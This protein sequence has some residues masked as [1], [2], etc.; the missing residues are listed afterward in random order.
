MLKC[1]SFQPDHVNS[2]QVDAYLQDGGH[3]DNITKRPL[4]AVV[5]CPGGGYSYVSNRENFPVGREFLGAGYH[6]FILTYSTGKQAKDFEPLCQLAAT[7]S[8]IRNHAEEW[9]VDPSK[10]AVCGFSAGGHLAAS[11]GTLALTEEF[12][13]VWKGGDNIIPNAMLLAYPVILSNEFAHSGSIKNVSG[14]KAGTASYGWFSLEQHVTKDTPPTFLWHTAAD[15]LVPVENSLYFSAALSAANVPFELHVFP[16][17]GHGMST[18]THEVGTFNAYN[19]R[20]IDFSI[21]WLNNLFD[22]TL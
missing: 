8:H 20:W 22:F 7:I 17:G 1:F 19:A 15:K 13:R 12:R 21:K 3:Y 9:M 16:S 5:V 18:C 6:V 11:S 2:C 14:S 4:P 10:I